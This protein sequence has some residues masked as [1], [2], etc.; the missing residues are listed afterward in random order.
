MIENVEIA[1]HLD[2]HNSQ[3][4]VRVKSN[5]LFLNEG[6]G[7]DVVQLCYFY[8][9]IFLPFSYIIISISIALIQSFLTPIFRSNLS[10][11]HAQHQ[12]GKRSSQTLCCTYSLIVG[13]TGMASLSLAEALKSPKA[14]GGPWKVYGSALPPMPTWF[15]FALLDRYISF[16]ATD[17][18]DTG[19]KLGAISNEVT[20]VFWVA[21][22]VRE[23]EEAN[24]IVNA[25][26]L[27]NVLD[28]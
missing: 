26:M 5:M 19:K 23:C 20:H 21:I 27:A 22:Q 11:T 15:P 17:S 3:I 6:G 7:M 4:S 14:L 18:D 9:C 28:V 13:V 10:Q 24:V 1:I 2:C 12:H 16:E 25:T 8:K